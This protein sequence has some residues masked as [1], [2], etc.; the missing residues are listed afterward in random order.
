MK[1]IRQIITSTLIVSSLMFTACKKQPITPQLPPPQPQQ[2]TG[3]LAK[4]VYDTGAF[5]SL[6]YLADGRIA[7]LVNNIDPV[8]GDGVSYNFVYDATGK[9][10]RINS[11]EDRSYRYS[12]ENGK[13]IAISEYINQHKSSYK[14]FNYVNDVLTSME[15]YVYNGAAR[16]YEFSALHNYSFYPDGNLKEE[17]AYAVNAFTGQ[18]VKHMTIEYSDYDNK[19]NAEELVRQVP[20]Y[21]GIVR[22]KNNPGKRVVKRDVPNITTIFNSIFTYDPQSKPMTKK[23][24]YQDPSGVLIETNT[25]F[26]YY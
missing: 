12:Y 3:K 18:L 7:K 22:L 4:L 19:F 9:V 25:L 23:F 6:Y 26:Y 21:F 15:I 2:P 11:S 14:L 1:Q 16:G 10:E 8:N 17:V 5:D 13:V 24:Q 20:Y